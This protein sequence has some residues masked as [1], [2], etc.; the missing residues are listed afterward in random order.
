MY[1]STVINQQIGKL[2]ELLN[3][4]GNGRITNLSFLLAMASS[5]VPA[6][7]CRAVP[8]SLLLTMLRHVSLPHLPRRTSHLIAAPS[9]PSPTCHAMPPSLPPSLPRLPPSYQWKSERDF[10][11]R[12]GWDFPRLPTVPCGHRGPKWGHNL[13]HHFDNMQSII[14]IFTTSSGQVSLHCQ[15]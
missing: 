9:S 8:P 11:Y 13:H 12:G 2:L 14:T 15:S 6:V 1:N 10:S 7:V 4:D 5:L 3:W